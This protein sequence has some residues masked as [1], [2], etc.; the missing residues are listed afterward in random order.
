MIDI[1]LTEPSLPSRV[2]LEIKIYEE[3][4]SLS[5]S[6]VAR[7]LA[8]ILSKSDLVALLKNLKEI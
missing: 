3:M 5:E 2:N 1:K 6:K 4:C 8:E 7:V